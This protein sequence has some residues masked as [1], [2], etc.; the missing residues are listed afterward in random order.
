MVVVVVVVVVCA[1][2]AYFKNEIKKSWR[3][4]GGRAQRLPPNAFVARNV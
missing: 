1:M 2:G 3:G 4:V